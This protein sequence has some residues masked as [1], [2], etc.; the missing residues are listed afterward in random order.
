MQVFPKPDISYHVGFPKSEANV[1]SILIPSWNNLDFLKIC[2]ASIVKNSYFKHQIIIHVNE[3]TDG[4]LEWVKSQGLDYSYS[5]TNA[6][7]CYAMNAMAKLS[8]TNYLLYI[9][10]DM[11]ACKDWDKQLWEQKLALGHD[12]FFISSTL[13]EPSLTNSSAV[14]A[15]YNFG[16]TP[17]EFNEQDLTEF[18]SNLKHPNWS[19]GTWP[20]NLV[21]K[22]LFEKV[23]GYSEEFSPGFGSDPDFA[24]KL[25]QEGVRDFIGVGS[26][27]AYHFLSKSTGRVKSNNGRKKFAKKWGIPSSYFYKY[28]L[29]MGA[30]LHDVGKLHFPKG[31]K[32][33]LA[34]LRAFYISIK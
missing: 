18:V 17:H 30:P 27:F 1:F 28:V 8:S 6:G 34:R 29:K 25:W 7:V 11:Y 32:F 19:G 20:P 2:V 9:N 26:S 4:T 23:G 5:S 33:V 14:I 24:M 22:S 21:S 31:F 16:T 13:I 15:P 12:H 3:G 10:D